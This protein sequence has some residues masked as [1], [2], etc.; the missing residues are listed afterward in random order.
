M[1][2]HAAV[3]GPYSEVFSICQSQNCFILEA[4]ITLNLFEPQKLNPRPTA[5]KVEK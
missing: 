2:V 4:S 3:L 1:P 5:L